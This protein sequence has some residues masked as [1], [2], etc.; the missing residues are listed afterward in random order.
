MPPARTGPGGRRPP[1]SRRPG[2]GVSTGRARRGG[3]RRSPSQLAALAAP[4][5]GP[6]PAGRT[7]RRGL[8]AA[9][10][11]GV[12]TPA[13][14]PRPA[15]RHL[16]PVPAASW[17]RHPLT[18]SAGRRAA[19]GRR[20]R[21]GACAPRATQ[22]DGPGAARRRRVGTGSAA[23]GLRPASAHGGA[24]PVT[25]GRARPGGGVRG[26][27][28]APLVGGRRR[29]SVLA[30]VCTATPALGTLAPP[31]P[32][33]PKKRPHLW[34]PQ[35]RPAP[36]ALPLPK[37]GPVSS[38]RHDSGSA[39]E[40]QTRLGPPRPRDP[41][42]APRQWREAMTLMRGLVE[43]SGWPACPQTRAGS[44]PTGDGPAGLEQVSVV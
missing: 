15:R 8:P 24:L 31:P 29:P 6:G 19:A 26:G 30:R 20:G 32:R 1:P 7:A 16:P 43:A 18:S 23:A 40:C 9:S 34:G 42:Q 44:I 25:R 39:T 3:G 14:R 28:E 5:R 36:G 21:A 41:P 17:P 27:K 35:P 11:A 37:P 12:E 10:R 33:L 22:S 13:P 38:F 2:E 4:D